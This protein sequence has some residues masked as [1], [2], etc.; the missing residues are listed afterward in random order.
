MT[1]DEVRKLLERVCRLYITQARKL[2]PEQRSAMVETWANEFANESY[3]AVDNAISAYMKQGKPFMPDVADVINMLN[4]NAKPTGGSSAEGD[5]LFSK[6]ETIADILANKKQRTSIVD[7]GGFRWSEK[8]QRNV[9][10]HA[11]LV[12]NCSSYTQYDFAQLPEEIQEYVEDID[13]LRL[14][15]KEIQSNRDMARRR[16]LTQLPE[17]KA[18]IAKRKEQNRREHQKR[19]QALM[20]AK[21]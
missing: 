19:L 2:S 7:P 21:A 4:D 10:F 12:V 15:Y 9:Y 18:E 1:R 6:M 3:T 14:I 5:R 17:I 20:E 11:E 13:G 8:H 16:F